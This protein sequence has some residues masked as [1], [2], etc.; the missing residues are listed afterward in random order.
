MSAGGR[1]TETSPPFTPPNSAPPRKENDREREEDGTHPVCLAAGPRP[2]RGRPRRP[3]PGPAA[4]PADA[5]V[6]GRR[7]PAP[8]AQQ[9]APDT[10]PDRQAAR[11]GLALGRLRV[12]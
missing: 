2:G 9:Q 6:R 8:P 3:C 4:D 1:R 5:N 7:G 10:V 12:L 11:R